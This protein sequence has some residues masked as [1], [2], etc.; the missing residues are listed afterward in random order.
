MLDLLRTLHPRG[1][2]VGFLP[3]I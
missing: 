3:T 1:A 2:W